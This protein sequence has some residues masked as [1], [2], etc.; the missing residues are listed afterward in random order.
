[1]PLSE[2]DAPAAIELLRETAALNHDDPVR[3]GSLLEFGSGGQLIMTGDM[4][5]AFR[6]FFK[7]QHFCDF[8][9]NPARY[10]ILH[11]LIHAEPQPPSNVDVSIDLLLQAAQWKCDFPDNVFF[12]QSNHELS[13]LCHHE[14]T[15][16]GRSVLQDFFRGMQHRFGDQAEAVLAALDEY[17]ASLALA[18]KTAKGIFLAHSLPDPG[19]IPSF[20]TSVFERPLRRVDMEPDGAAYQ[21]VWGRFQSPD[22]VDAFCERVGAKLCVVGHTPQDEGVAVTGNMLIVESDHAH[23]V[24]LPIDL[25]RTYTIDELAAR[26]KKFVAIE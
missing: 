9:R 11:E 7:L 25:S 26:A 19:D 3:T 17:I 13:Q 15:K 4:H 8:E 16:G 10:V 6:N 22:D 23:G 2:L 12:L 5:G 1:M 18:A 14:I 20:D 21:L 24:L